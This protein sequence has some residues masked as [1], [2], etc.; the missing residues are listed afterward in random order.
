VA[1]HLVASAGDK[2]NNMRSVMHPRL[3]L[4]LFALGLPCAASAA[5]Y[6]YTGPNYQF[7]Q[8]PYTAA[9][10]MSGSFTTTSPLPASMSPTD[11]GPNG[12]NLV[13]GWSFNDGVNTFTQANSVP[14]PQFGT[15]RIGTDASGNINAFYIQL[16]SPLPP[17]AVNQAMNSITIANLGLSQGQGVITTCA[18]LQGNVCA[19][20]NQATSYGSGGP[21]SF[22]TIAPT[23]PSIV[24]A[25][26]DVTIAVNGV[27]TLAFNITNPNASTGLTGV[28]F[29]DTLP[30]GME[31]ANPNG[32]SSTCGGVVTAVPGAGTISLTGAS[33]AAN[34]SCGISVNV[35][36]TS[37][38]AKNNSVTVTSIEGGQGNTSNA[39]I[40]AVTALAPAIAKA[41]ASGLL[42]QNATTGLTFT[43]TN[44][45]ASVGLT[46]VAFTDSLPA[47]MVVA[48]P[49]A[50]ASTC[51]GTATAVAGSASVSLTG[52]TVAAAGSCTVSVNVLVVQLGTLVNSVSVT[53]AEGGAGNTANATVTVSAAPAALVP[54]LSQ[55]G[56]L[57]LAAM[58]ALA[59][60][61]QHRR[62]RSL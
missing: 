31:V 12:T 62:R 21:G 13:T 8:A 52:G 28:A 47:G 22:T 61:A 5:T 26:G 60:L 40:T 20:L 14:L 9:M 2:T 39:S 42:S 51:G 1:T 10:S 15:F 24:K 56:L 32:F 59:G 4:V 41:F 46:G 17:H 43:I 34:T 36:L 57:L 27:T 11:I 44:P 7:V 25:F 30:A 23:P 35:L 6:V 38:G 58:I 19:T 16:E 45:N 50:L 29:T 54:T 53:S 48:T 18:A 37:T 49:N 3:A 33:I 55:W